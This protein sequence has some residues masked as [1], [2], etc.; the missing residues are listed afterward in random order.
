MTNDKDKKDKSENNN[1]EL[2]EKNQVTDDSHTEEDSQTQDDNLSQNNEWQITEDAIDKALEE[3]QQEIVASRA[4]RKAT[5]EAEES[6]FDNMTLENADADDDNLACLNCGTP[7]K[8]AYCYECGQP[9]RHFI[10]FFPRVLWDMINEAFDLDSKIFR[11]FMPLMFRPGSLTLEYI[12]GRR[13]RYINPLRLY[14]VISLIF[15]LVL[16]MVARFSGEDTSLINVDDS[17]VK[18]R[19]TVTDDEGNAVAQVEDDTTAD[20]SPS[21]RQ[22]NLESRILQLQAAKE[23]GAPISQDAIDKVEEELAKVRDDPATSLEIAEEE[24]EMAVTFDDGT[25]WHPETNPVTF[26]NI[27]SPD[28]TRQLNEFLWGLKNKMKM[29]EEEPREFVQEV[30]D[31]F[32]VL[33]FFLLPLFA[34]ILKIVYIFKKRYYM[35]HLVIA[36]HSHSFIFFI[37]LM[38]FL[39]DSLG[40]YSLV[41]FGETSF[42]ANT[43]DLALILLAIWLPINLFLQQKRV[44]AQ[45]KFMTT[46][47]FMFVGIIYFFLLMF[48]ALVSGVLGLVNL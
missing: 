44:Y 41:V 20:E 45:G 8:G 39:V 21:V 17:G 34:L 18:S 5:V 48:T 10:R 2:P 9:E 19:V 46:I 6:M 29:I 32:P 30:F 13:A 1:V 3:Q 38:M 43:F 22:R 23:A 24:D 26:D 36:L 35:E 27:F 14:I 12:A 7:M 25:V 15:F 37:L 42:V 16:S 31:V 4:E 40:E 47:K 28:T 11:T 33:M